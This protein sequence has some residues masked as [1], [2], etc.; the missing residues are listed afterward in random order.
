M[1]G[2]T[3]TDCA[4]GLWS[5]QHKPEQIWEEGISVADLPPP[6]CPVG[7]GL[8]LGKWSCVV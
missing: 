1:L 8:F 4:G 5:T 2:Q 3:Q 7:T 6:D